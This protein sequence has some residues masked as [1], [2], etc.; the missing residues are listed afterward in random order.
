M[1]RLQF[2][3]RASAIVV[4]LGLFSCTAE[5]SS[6]DPIASLQA[7]VAA[8]SPDSVAP[9]EK[10][11]AEIAVTNPSYAGFWFDTVSNHF[12]VGVTDLTS[13][14]QIASAVRGRLSAALAGS[15][16]IPI[17]VRKVNYSFAQLGIWRNRMRALF[18]DQRVVGLD[19]DE[20]ANLVAVYAADLSATGDIEEI[21]RGK[22]LPT[23]ALKII[24]SGRSVPQVLLTDKRRPQIE[25]GFKFEYDANPLQIGNCTMGAD[26][27]A[28]G[29]K[30]GFITASHC[31][32]DPVGT[33]IPGSGMH[34][35]D[36]WQNLCCGSNKIADEAIDPPRFTGAG[37][38][39]GST[40]RLSDALWADYTSDTYYS[41]KRVAETTVIG[42]GSTPGST[43]FALSRPAP[44][45]A[46]LPVGLTVRK[47]GQATGTTQG[48]VATHCIDLAYPAPNVWLLCQ[49]Q[50]DAPSAKGDSGSPIYFGFNYADPNAPVYHA[51]IL[52]GG[53]IPCQQG[54]NLCVTTRLNLSGWYNIASD[55]GVNY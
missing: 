2:A 39:A 46:S 6:D 44:Q 53:V 5:P 51:G 32:Y 26:V 40:C 10:W 16:R 8:F 50:V 43:T 24:A 13:G 45:S 37:C 33:A 47:T 48:R 49:D 29:L 22:G 25:N 36:M 11:D 12:V 38:P 1:S 28:P 27:I 41:G 23:E 4:L 14:A 21:A 19:L 34:G 9:G 55:L 18:S 3:R 7:A 54:G 31:S 20:R 35:T 17:D 42:S 30:K 15:E 52:W